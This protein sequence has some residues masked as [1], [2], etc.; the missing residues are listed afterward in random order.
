MYGH[1]RP[2]SWP[3]Y[4][5]MYGHRRTCTVTPYMSVSDHHMY[6]PFRTC[7]MAGHVRCSAHTV[8]ADKCGI[9][10][11]GMSGL[12][13]EPLVTIYEIYI[14]ADIHMV[15]HPFEWMHV[16]P[17]IHGIV[18]NIESVRYVIR[19]DIIYAPIYCHS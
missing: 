6:G 12:T 14:L 7:R 18:I 9:S 2:R 15:D 4:G 1:V 5:L 17:K 13:R 8:C 16:Y 10:T 19:K 11:W 3:M